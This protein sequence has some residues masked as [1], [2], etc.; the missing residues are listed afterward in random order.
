[1]V[2]FVCGEACG[3]LVAPWE[4]VSAAAGAVEVLLYGEQPGE[5]ALDGEQ[6]CVAGF[7]AGVDGEAFAFADC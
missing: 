6:D 3:E 1:V 2:C 5:V 7:G 4:V